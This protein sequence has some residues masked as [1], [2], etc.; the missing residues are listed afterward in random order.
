MTLLRLLALGVVTVGLTDDARRTP[1]ERRTAMEA[2][3]TAIEA[4]RARERE[5]P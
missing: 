2:W 1:E 5:T 3:R 4:E